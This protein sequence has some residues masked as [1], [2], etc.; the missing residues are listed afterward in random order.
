MF[1]RDFIINDLKHQFNLS[2]QIV[3]PITKRNANTFKLQI[4]E[5]S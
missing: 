1:V 2:V 4:L 3:T 5:G